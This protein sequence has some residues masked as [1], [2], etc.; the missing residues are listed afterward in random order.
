MAEG[1]V[2]KI[3]IGRVRKVL[4]RKNIWRREI[5][6]DGDL[7]DDMYAVC[8]WYSPMSRTDNLQYHFHEVTDLSNT[9][10]SKLFVWCALI[11]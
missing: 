8:E 6:L 9:R 4:K 3:W 5:L 1:T 11:L 10:L 2:N 7:P